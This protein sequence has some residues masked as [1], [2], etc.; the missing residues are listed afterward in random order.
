M[1]HFYS[2]VTPGRHLRDLDYT[3]DSLAI[4]DGDISAFPVT[5][6]YI[7]PIPERFYVIWFHSIYC[8]KAIRIA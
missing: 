5:M 2:S 4:V 8:V 3:T 7:Y 1:N 6:K